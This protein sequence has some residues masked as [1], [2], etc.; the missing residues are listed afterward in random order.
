M[1]HTPHRRQ[2]GYIVQALALVAGCMAIVEIALR[3]V[4]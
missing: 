4:K 2:V 1:K 3:I